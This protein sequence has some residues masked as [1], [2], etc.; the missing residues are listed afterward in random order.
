MLD[1]YM[2]LTVSIGNATAGGTSFTIT[3]N[4]DGK[5]QLQSAN[6]SYEFKPNGEIT[7]YKSSNVAMYYFPDGSIIYDSG[8]DIFFLKN[9]T[10]QLYDPNTSSYIMVNDTS[11]IPQVESYEEA[12][13]NL[14]D[15]EA[16]AKAFVDL[17]RGEIE[18]LIEKRLPHRSF[19]IFTS[20]YAF[21]WYDYLIGYDAILAEF[22]WNNTVAQEIGLARGA[23]N[24]QNKSWGAMITWKYTH[25]P[26]MASGDEI[27][28]QMRSA[29]KAG[30]DYLVVFNYAEDM[31]SPYGILKPEHFDA[32]KRFWNEVVQNPYVT[33]SE[34]KAEA[35]FVLPKNC[36][37]SLRKPTDREWGFRAP[38]N[39]VQHAMN[40]IE[41]ALARHGLRLD[42]IYNDP[43]YP[44]VGKYNQVYYWNQTD[45]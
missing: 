42:I 10:C 34:G 12:L 32:L 36:G 37:W 38:S 18:S 30:A 33:N 2:E 14:P 21:Y 8:S 24:L 3:K 45:V 25:P 40:L 41:A 6:E 13:A 4:A 17:H 11:R 44:Y 5:I 29:Y 35:A 43:A 19:P 1:S 22:G 26:Y 20:D 7:V 31:E 27:Y 16:A 23:A 15:S 9:G 39:E 28:D